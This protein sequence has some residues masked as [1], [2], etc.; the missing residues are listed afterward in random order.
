MFDFFNAKR[1]LQNRVEELE[2]ALEAERLDSNKYK[3]ALQ[4]I[5]E[6]APRIK[7]G[8]LEA[9]IIN[10]DKYGDLSSTLAD[11]NGMLDLTDAF[12]REATAS[13]DAAADGN[14]YR[15]FLPQGMAGAYG[16]G[17]EKINKTTRGM[18]DTENRQAAQREETAQSFE[19]SVM[20]VVNGLIK[21]VKQ[22]KETAD[23]LKQYASEN[24]SLATN[25]AAAAEQATANVQTVAAA[26]E[27][28]SASVEEITRQVNTSSEKTEEASDKAKGTASTIDTLQ[29]ASGTIGQVVNLIND[30]AE[31]TN[32]LALNAT[33]EAARAGD[34]GKGFAVVASE[35]KSL[36]QQ[37]AHA[38][39]EIGSQVQSIQDNTSTTVSAV[40]GISSSI[41]S[42][43]D[44]ASTIAA[45]AEQQSAATMEI[46]RNI[47]EASQ[48]T[49]D[50]SNNIVHVNE[51]ASQTM[52]R[53]EE[54]DFAADKLEQQIMALRSQSEQFLANVRCA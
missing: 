34:A 25:V 11:V 20:A 29:V 14:Y 44:I 30:I 47:Q 53:A 16:V 24:K 4:E 2:A 40:S 27:E 54:L 32:L 28:L 39:G 19:Q 21:S 50:V 45:A 41:T 1:K 42:L 9:R 33:I 46:S 13:L 36:A 31:Q 12:I 52:N 10:W 15:R 3:N 35:V 6:I 23:Q 48:G 37:T 38:T 7:N 5:A 26:T 49:Q 22:T 43:N 18:Q 51:T 8:D 17:A